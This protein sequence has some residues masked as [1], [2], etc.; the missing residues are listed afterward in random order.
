MS[1]DVT[2]EEVSIENAGRELR[3][4]WSRGRGGGK[5][6][7]IYPSRWLVEKA[8]E[9]AAQR[10]VAF[11]YDDGGEEW[12]SHATDALFF[13]GEAHTLGPRIHQRHGGA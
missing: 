11:G 4:L 3:L 10:Y 9:S 2:P 1:R 13:Q 8:A 5:H 6:E 12:S 7:S